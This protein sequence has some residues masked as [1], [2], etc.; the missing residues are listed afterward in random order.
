MVNKNQY[1]KQIAL[2]ANGIVRRNPRILLKE[3][4]MNI[5]QKNPYSSNHLQK[6]ALDC[7]KNTRLR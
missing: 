7:G 3:A 6:D 5:E 1:F 4:R 2:T